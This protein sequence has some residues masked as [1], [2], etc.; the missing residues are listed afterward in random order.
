MKRTVILFLDGSATHKSKKVSDFCV[1]NI[2]ILYCLQPNTT[3]IIQP[4]D[5]LVVLNTT[6][7]T[8]LINSNKQ[9]R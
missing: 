2:I 5:L 8:L 7:Q 1:D 6:G 3:H 9:S 4:L